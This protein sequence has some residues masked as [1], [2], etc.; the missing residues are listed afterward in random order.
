VKKK[1]IRWIRSRHPSQFKS[2]EWG[3]VVNVLERRG[4]ACFLVRFDDLSSDWWPVDDT[5]ARYEF[6]SGVK[7][8]AAKAA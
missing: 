4:Q 2:G 5:E 8:R 7:P 3:R 1:P 6:A